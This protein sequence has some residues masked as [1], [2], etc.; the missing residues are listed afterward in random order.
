M[1]SNLLNVSSPYERFWGT[2]KGT[3][4]IVP[5]LPL[6]TFISLAL[7]TALVSEDPFWVDLKKSV[8]MFPW[9]K[10]LPKCL[11]FFTVLPLLLSH[12]LQHFALRLVLFLENKLPLRL[13]TFLDRM[14]DQ[15]IFEDTRR[16]IKGKKQRGA[17]WRFRHRILQDYFARVSA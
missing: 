12:I 6:V 11:L 4:W 1:T 5:A 17:S 9:L 7:S 13:V 2:F 15:Y 10:I 14:T 8:L 16:T 3:L